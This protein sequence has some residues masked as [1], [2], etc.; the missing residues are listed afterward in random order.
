[1]AAGDSLCWCFSLPQ[2]LAVPD[3]ASPAS[4]LCPACLAA[5]I[6]LQGD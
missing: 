3:A 2:V 6:A 5:A 4:C 1:M